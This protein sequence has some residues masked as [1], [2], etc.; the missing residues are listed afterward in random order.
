MLKRE[1]NR[2]KKT[3]NYIIYS[4]WSLQKCRCQT[5]Q[6]VNFPL[7]F[8]WRSTLYVSLCR[9]N[10]L[11]STNRGAVNTSMRDAQ[12]CELGLYGCYGLLGIPDWSHLGPGLRWCQLTGCVWSTCRTG[13][14]KT[15]SFWT[16]VSGTPT[17]QPPLRDNQPWPRLRIRGNRPKTCNRFNI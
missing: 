17:R 10:W 15:A 6:F 12:R 1:K 13:C 5:C 8:F 9:K 3:Q 7:T 14:P 11:I 4:M 16:L 2:R